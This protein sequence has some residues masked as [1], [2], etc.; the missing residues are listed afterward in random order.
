MIR[1]LLPPAIYHTKRHNE[2]VINQLQKNSVMRNS[3]DDHIFFCVHSTR[4]RE[5][6]NSKIEEF[7]NERL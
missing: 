1:G 2:Q 6:K 3:F 4:I 7:Q 5:Q